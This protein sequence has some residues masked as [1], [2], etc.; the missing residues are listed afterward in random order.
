MAIEELASP[1]SRRGRLNR[2]RVV[3]AAIALAD[4][5]GAEALSMRRL[6]QDL[7]V[8]P[9]ALYKHVSDKDELL[10]AMIDAVFSRV[11]PPEPGAGWQ[12]ALRATILS[13]RAALLRHPWAGQVI[14]SRTAPTPAIQ[15]HMD[16]IIGI[17][18]RGGFS[19]ELIHHLMH[20]LGSRV[21]GFSQELDMFQVPR[22]AAG[23]PVLPPPDASGRYPNAT[24]LVT[25]VTHDGKSVVGDGCDD[26]LEFEFALDFILDGIERLRAAD[27]AGR[28]A[29]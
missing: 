19:I 7:G 15:A 23:N 24:A 1:P 29:A 18:R 9:M 6:A 20:T 11:A 2:E 10:D 21:L 14:Q 25:A 12:A 4:E 3:S 8:V 16:A 26:Q 13:A 5:N 22:D 17:F 28:G 27:E